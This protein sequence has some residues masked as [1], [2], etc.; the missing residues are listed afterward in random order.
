[1]NLYLISG[2]ISYL[3]TVEK[4]THFKNQDIITEEPLNKLIF[5]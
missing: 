1:M 3:I 5:F 2:K 4:D